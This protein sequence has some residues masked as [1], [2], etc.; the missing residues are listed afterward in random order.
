MSAYVLDASYALAWCFED[1]ATPATDES[2]RRLQR[3]EDTVIVPV[4][5]RVEVPNALGKAVTRGKISIATALGMWAGL[6]K[7]PIRDV[8]GGD[9]PELIRLATGHGIFVYDANYLRAAI[10]SDLPLATN[11]NQLA[12]VA[13]KVG[14]ALMRP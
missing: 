2:L 3:E 10:V 7:R 8:P 1:R 14:V 13:S 12:S 5:W 9:V 4:I 6:E 11:D